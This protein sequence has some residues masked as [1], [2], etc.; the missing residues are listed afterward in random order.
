[1][2]NILSVVIPL[3]VSSGHVDTPAVPD[4]VQEVLPRQDDEGQPSG[5]DQGGS[6]LKSLA[7]ST[8]KIFLRGVKESADAF[9]PLKSVAGGLCYILD[10]YEV[11]PSSSIH[12]GQR[13]QVPQQTKANTQ[14]VE[15]LA[16]RVK[17]LSASLC[18]SISENDFKERGRRKRLEQ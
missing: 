2:N 1:V 14:T 7:S 15:S 5:A 3:T 17:A 13:L 10:N 8:A 11:R 16:P 18:A 9:P 6:N 4:I 12:Y